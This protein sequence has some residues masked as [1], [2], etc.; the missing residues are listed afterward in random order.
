MKKL[1]NLLFIFISFLATSQ[2]EQLIWPREIEAGNYLITLYQPQYETLIENNLKGRLALSIKTKEDK[3]IFGSLWFE[4]RLATDLETRI[5]NLESIQIE[6]IIFPD[7]QN[8]ENIE[9]LKSVLLEDFKKINIDISID[10]LIASLENVAEEQALSENLNNKPPKIF[11][12]QESTVLVTIDGEPKFK[13][14]EGEKIDY[15]VNT[16][17]F[18]VKRKNVFYLKGANFWY[19]AKDLFANNWEVTSSVPTD[20]ENLADKNFESQQNPDIEEGENTPPNLILVTEP[21]E[22]VV[23]KGDLAYEPINNTTLLYVTNTES[24]LLLEI[25]SQT[26]YLLLNGRWYATKAIK[27]EEWQFVEPKNLP[28][29]FLDIPSDNEKVSGLRISIPGTQEAKDALYEQQIPQTAVVDRKKATTNVTYDGDPKF[30]KIEDTNMSYAVNTE[31]TVLLIQKKYYVVDNGV[32]F[33]SNNANGPW[34]VATERP[35][36]VK[37]IPPSSPVNN[38]KYV[39][40]YDSTPDVVYV[41]YTPGY[42]HSYVYGGVVVYGSGYY[43][44]PWYG[45]YYYPRPVTYGFGVHYNP[46]TGWGFSVGVSYGWMTVS[47]HSRA[48]WGPCGYRYGYRHGYRHGYHRGYA[49]GYAH[50]KRNSNNIYRTQQG[51]NRPGISSRTR[52]STNQISKPRPTNNRKNNLYSDKNGNVHQRDKNGNWQQKRNNNNTQR[53]NKTQPAPQNRQN[54]ENHYNNR[55]RGNNNYKNY[56]STRPQPSARRRR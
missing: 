21:S 17:F 56:R 43:Y 37:D 51:K 16:P 4:A 26:H 9:V 30:E 39:Y 53:P 3:M 49:A 11:F 40:I 50:G 22:L 23:T 52:P 10:K 18:I 28:K 12:R 2:E 32:W 6:K 25:E 29:T 33:E 38:V 42:Y 27:K 45:M 44:Y 55:N 5:A 35:E 13:T 31:S 24:D 48:Y 1:A 8:D 14:V 36:E 20:I 47:F 41:G 54:L 7:I 46:Y 19:K 15:V 34:T